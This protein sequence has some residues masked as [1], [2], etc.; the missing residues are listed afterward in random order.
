MAR[1]ASEIIKEFESRVAEVLYRYNFIDTDIVCIVPREDMDVIRELSFRTI[2]RNIP[3]GNGN[4]VIKMC[5]I[6]TIP[7]DVNRIYVCLD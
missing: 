5:G 3:I 6:K 2:T 7:A 4:E 1:E